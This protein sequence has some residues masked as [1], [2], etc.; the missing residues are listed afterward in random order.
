MRQLV[1]GEN[2]RNELEHSLVFHT[3][4]TGKVIRINIEF[5]DFPMV[6]DIRSDN[7]LTLSS[8]IY[9]VDDFTASY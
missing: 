2:L 4:P 1:V 9:T 8:T 5:G 3:G 7:V 6:L